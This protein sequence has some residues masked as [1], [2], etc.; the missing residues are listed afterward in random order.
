MFPAPFDYHRAD[1]VEDA[2][3]LLGEHDEA[4]LLA[5]GHSL[6]PMMKLRLAQ[7]SVLVDIGRCAELAGTRRENGSLHIGALTTHAAIHASDDVRSACPLLCEAAGTVGDP[8]VRNR[9]TIGGNIAHA[10]PASDLP[11]VLVAAGA[12]VHVRAVAGSR[13]VAASDFFVDLLTTDLQPREIMTAV[14]ISAARPGTGSCYLKVEHPASGFAVC[15]AA[16]IVRMEGGR[17]VEASLV[18]NGVT[19]TPLVADVTSLVGGDAADGAIESAV[20]AIG[21]EDPLGDLHASGEYRVA[22][23]RVY[24]GRALRRAR[25]RASE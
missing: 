24:G 18:F 20:A 21:A 25:D 2:L 9:G 23:A 8:Q 4:K 6:L 17:C 22:L 11:A 12:T 5:G 19:A 3:R 1:S 7:P 14:E 15:G 10:D 16:A 13:A